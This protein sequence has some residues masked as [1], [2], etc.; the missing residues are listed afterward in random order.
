[1]SFN[2]LI[3]SLKEIINQQGFES[4]TD[5]QKKTIPLIKGGGNIFGIGPKNSGKTT[6]TI[7]STI[8]KLKGYAKDDNPRAIIIVKDKKSALDLE[9]AFKTFTNETDL[10][11][12]TIYEEQAISKQKDQLYPGV[13]IVIAT[14]RRLNKLYFL[15]GI[16][17]S[18]L[19]LIIVEDAD[20]LMGTTFHTEIHRITESLAKCQYVVFAS[21]FNYKLD[22]LKELF[23]EKAQLVVV[24]S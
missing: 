18:E 6:A 17:L 2:K 21:E 3:P 22:K 24:K 19:Q 13:D 23:M 9:E 8:Q 14:P 15:N 12:F 11:V 20:Q 1:M 16:N 4:P 5:F 7:I 10:R